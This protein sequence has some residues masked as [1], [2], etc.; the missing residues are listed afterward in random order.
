[1]LP[2]L[3]A[4]ALVWVP[5]EAYTHWSKVDALLRSRADLKLTVALTPQMATPLAKAALGPWVALGRVEIAAGGNRL[6]H[7]GPSRVRGRHQRRQPV[8]GTRG[9]DDEVANRHGVHRVHPFLQRLHVA[10]RA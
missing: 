3:L 6:A 8:L 10:T 5:P 2:A 7:R 1:M 9:P 4:A